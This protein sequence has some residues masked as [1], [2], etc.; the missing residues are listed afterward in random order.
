[1]FN[2]GKGDLVTIVFPQLG[3]F[4]EDLLALFPRVRAVSG[5]LVSG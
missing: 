5:F 3:E 2:R 4:V 1:V